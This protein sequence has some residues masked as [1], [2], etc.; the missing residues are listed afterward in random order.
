STDPK[1]LTEA[2]RTALDVGYP[3]IDTAFV[4]GNE[5]V[6]GNVLHEYFSSGKLKREDIF[7][8]TKLPF[9]V[10]RPAEIEAVV[11]KQLKDL[12][13]DYIDL[14]LIHVPCP[15]KPQP[16]GTPA[17]GY[18]SLIENGQLVPDPVDHV[19]TWKALEKL[20]KDGKLKAIGLSNFNQKQIQHIIDHATVKPHNLQVETHI[21]WPQKELFDFCKKNGITFTSYGPIGSPGRKTFRPEGNW[22]EGEPM[23]DPLVLELAKKYNKTPAQVPAFIAS[24]ANS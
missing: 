23:K 22:P 17:T 16:G 6:I 7:I 15:C 5:A 10:H 14:Y 2:V 20:H 12:Q 1:A 9:L 4:Y 21:Y 11:E 8:T 24:F 19:D 18:K 13:I 3:L